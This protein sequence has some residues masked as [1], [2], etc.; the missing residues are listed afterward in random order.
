MLSPTI[1]KIG[2]GSTLRSQLG[3]VGENYID[4]SGYTIDLPKHPSQTS[5]INKTGQE[6]RTESLLGTDIHY[7]KNRHHDKNAPEYQYSLERTYGS[8]P[9]ILGYV[10]SATIVYI[11]FDVICDMIQFLQIA[12]LKSNLTIRRWASYTNK[13]NRVMLILKSFK[14][15]PICNMTVRGFNPD[16]D[17][18]QESDKNWR[19]LKLARERAV[20]RPTGP[21]YS[22]K[23]RTDRDRLT[24]KMVVN[25]DIPKLL[26]Y[27]DLAGLT[28][29]ITSRELS[30]SKGKGYKARRLIIEPKKANYGMTGV[31]AWMN[32]GAFDEPENN[33]D[34]VMALSGIGLH[35]QAGYEAVDQL[36]RTVINTDV[37]E[38]TNTQAEDNLLQDECIS[39]VLVETNDVRITSDDIIRMMDM[40]LTN[41]YMGE[42]SRAE[43]LRMIDNTIENDTNAALKK[44]VINDVI[45]TS[46][47]NI[48]EYEFTIQNQCS[49]TV[50][51]DVNHS[52]LAMMSA[53]LP[54]GSV[55]FKVPKDY[56]SKQGQM[57]LWKQTRSDRMAGEC[58]VTLK[59]YVDEY[60]DKDKRPMED[61]VEEEMDTTEGGDEMSDS[62]VSRNP[63]KKKQR[64]RIEWP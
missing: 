57:W 41:T 7:I 36:T 51:Y 20:M 1:L 26:E 34:D 5:S 9:K 2:D 35:C 52:S 55:S 46:S 32:L 4:I 15:D 33:E 30:Q 61:N 25:T 6:G 14:A 3:M 38:F 12:M 37:Y 23:V 13:I 31:P 27:R 24:M 59:D 56:V 8:L 60:H 64:R 40:K 16:H 49:N 43:R 53:I 44:F 18:V 45:I 10:T 21:V 22:T 54:W 28:N 19:D 62:G 48:K 39:D 50:W 11:C 29:D 42:I 58:K 47:N 63:A 17:I